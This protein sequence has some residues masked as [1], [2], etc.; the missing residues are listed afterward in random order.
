[1]GDSPLR[2]TL[3][4]GTRP[5]FMKIAS[6]IHAIR[7][8]NMNAPVVEYTLVHT[9]QHYNKNLSDVFFE[10]LEMPFPDINLEVGSGTQSFQTGQ[11][12]IKFEE[13]LKENDT[14]YV[15]V[16]GDVNS[17]MACSLVAKKIGI[18]VVHVEAGLQSGDMSMPEEI[19]RLVTDAIC[20]LFFTT[21]LDA[22]LNL[23]NR[24]ISKEKIKL[25]GNTMIDSL[26]RNLPRF[27]APRLWKEQM[28]DEQQYFLLTLH[29][30]S[31]VDDESKLEKLLT[32]V[33]KAAMPHKVIF[34]V[35]PRTSN[36]IG[37]LQ[38][39]T[40]NLIVTE[41]LRYLEFLHLVRYAKA[42]VTDSGGIQEETTFLQIP[43]LTLRENTERPET[44]TEGT[45]VLL[46]DNSVN[47]TDAIVS[48]KQGQWKEGAIPLLWDGKAGERIIA[49]LLKEK[50]GKRT[51]VAGKVN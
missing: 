27:R 3:V 35:H 44:I 43:C 5:N 14:D 38:I 18:P 10:D 9:G 23:V 39:A 31:N 42:V 28:L 21:T 36:K 24:G 1:M 48:V 29:R 26:V 30:P 49:A 37:N 45:N 17:T 25:V 32:T 50:A 16:V 47:I 33:L 20:D 40:D 11:I 46:G 6:L 8:V 34:P 12:M 41:P 13:Y 19:N 51:A 2:L 22:S 15:V 4:A 7:V